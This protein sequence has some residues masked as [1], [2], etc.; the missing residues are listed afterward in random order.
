MRTHTYMTKNTCLP[1]TSL[2]WMN[3]AGKLFRTNKRQEGVPGA[4]SMILFRGNIYLD[5]TM[6]FN[7][8]SCKI[9]TDQILG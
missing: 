5:F 8:I 7:T 3:P 6:L 2:H 9:V 1:L 4:V